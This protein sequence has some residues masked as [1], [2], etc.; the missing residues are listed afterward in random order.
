MRPLLA[1]QAHHIP[2]HADCFPRHLRLLKVE[3]MAVANQG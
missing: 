3:S 2:L 1:A